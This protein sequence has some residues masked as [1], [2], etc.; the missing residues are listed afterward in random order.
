MSP[1]QINRD[2]SQDKLRIRAWMAVLALMVILDQTLGFNLELERISLLQEEASEWATADYA[3]GQDDEFLV[4][5]PTGVTRILYLSNSHAFTGG[6]VPV[7]LQGFLDQLAPGKF[8]IVNLA[9][10]GIFAPEILQR[11][12]RALDY[13]I[14]VVFLG[15]NYINF[16]DRMRLGLQAHSTR[17]FFN[18]G[19]FHRLPLGFWTRNYDLGLYNSVFAEKTSKLYRN[20]NSLRNIWEIPLASLLKNISGETEQIFF[21]EM[22][23]DERWRFPDG[24]DNN[25]F[26]WNL[27]AAGRNNHLADIEA[28]ISKFE[29]NDIPVIAAN[30]PIDFNKSL[31]QSSQEDLDNYRQQLTDITSGL[32]DFVDYQADFPVDFSTYD[33]LHPTWHGARLHAFDLLLRLHR[34]GFIPQFSEQDL[35]EVFI[36][37]DEAV[38]SSYQALLNGPITPHED[39]TSFKRYEP[40]EPENARNLLSHLLATNPGS[41]LHTI[42]LLRLAKVIRYWTEGS[43]YKEGNQPLPVTP[44]EQAVQIEMTRS[45]E[46]MLYFRDILERQESLRL[47]RLSALD[48]SGMTEINRRDMSSDGLNYNAVVYRL[49]DDTSM[50]ALSTKEGKIFA[51]G[52]QLPDGTGYYLIDLIGNGSFIQAS[53]LDRLFFP[54]W[55]YDGP[56]LPDWGI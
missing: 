55:L 52:Y 39:P 19:I 38:S 2:I 32:N 24:Y 9:E 21:L 16:S 54:D 17:S 13:E 41:Q 37:S 1:Q 26:Q 7:H 40:S 44:F 22:E 50:L 12:L 6:N 4:A 48:E 18:N 10:P 25:L 28:L 51:K 45:R 23:Q 8:E 47:S 11:G 42:Q 33:A 3:Y 46:R 20:R 36:S 34:Q 53:P 27:Y 49:A 43:F 56:P 31:Y 5:K 29:Q 30:L 15:L 35:L 14:D